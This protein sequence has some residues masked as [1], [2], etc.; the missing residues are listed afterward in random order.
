MPDLVQDSSSTPPAAPSAVP[1]TI[2]PDAFEDFAVFRESFLMYIS[3][4]SFNA[5][6][7]T[8]AEHFF[9]MML[10]SYDR[11]PA[12]QETSTRMELRAAVA[13][14]RHLQGFLASIGQE[15]RYSSLDA[16]DAKL[17]KHA[18][19]VARLL[20]QVADTMEHK[21]AKGAA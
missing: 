10:E 13:D 11:W 8:A 21:L 7:R 14:M 9:T 5:A 2:H 15:R 18:S 17:S 3:E 19:R 12:W 6:L 4:P 16:G 1:A 20:K